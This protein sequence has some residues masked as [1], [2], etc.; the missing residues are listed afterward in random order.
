MPL[1]DMH[2]GHVN[3]TAGF[4]DRPTYGHAYFTGLLHTSTEYAYLHTYTGQTYLTGLQA[5][6]LDKYT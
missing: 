4:L 1:L 3:W 2:T 6:L 5:G